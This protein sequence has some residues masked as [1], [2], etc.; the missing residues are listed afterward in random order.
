MYK[1]DVTNDTIL[2]ITD[3]CDE[4]EEKEQHDYWETLLQNLK[5]VTGG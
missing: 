3:F 2:E 4:G 5:K 1:S